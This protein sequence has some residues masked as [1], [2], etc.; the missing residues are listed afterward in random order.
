MYPQEMHDWTHTSKEM[1]PAQKNM[2]VW[3]FKNEDLF[4]VCSQDLQTI[5]ILNVEEKIRDPDPTQTHLLLPTNHHKEQGATIESGSH[6]IIKVENMFCS[7]ARYN[8][9][10][11]Q[12]ITQLESPLLLGPFL[13]P[14]E[15]SQPF[16]AS[17]DLTNISSWGQG[18]HSTDCRPVPTYDSPC[19]CVRPEA[20]FMTRTLNSWSSGYW[21]PGGHVLTP[22]MWV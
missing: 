10:R 1:C 8:R 5:R 9:Q 13:S 20:P 14:S 2:V 22:R 12:Q 17:K 21:I 15:P 7:T 6:S 18:D 19:N 4:W 3:R 16:Q 11:K